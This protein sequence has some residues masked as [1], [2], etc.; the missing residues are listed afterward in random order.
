MLSLFLLGMLA[1]EDDVLMIPVI[2]TGFRVIEEGIVPS[3]VVRDDTSP[4][5]EL[6]AMLMGEGTVFA[7]VSI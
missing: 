3:K 1:R 6:V 7:L 5:F 4:W 2:G